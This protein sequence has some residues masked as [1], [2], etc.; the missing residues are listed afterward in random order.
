MERTSLDTVDMD[1]TIATTFAHHLRFTSD[2]L[3]PAN[4]VLAEALTVEGGPVRV[5]PFVDT[6]VAAAMPDLP[7]RLRTYFDAYES[8]ELAGRVQPVVGGELCKN[9]RDAV[10][11]VL[12]A[13]QEAGLDRQSFVLA[14]GGGAVLDCVGFAAAIAHRGM[15]LVRLPTTTL[16]QGDSGVGVKNGIN[17]FGQKN[18]LGSFAVPWAVINDEGFLATLSERDWRSGFSEAVKVALLKDADLFDQ[19]CEAAPAV[20]NRQPEVT[21]PLLQRSAELHLEHI[22]SGGDPFELGTGRPLDFGHWA[23]HKLETL[24]NF[25]LRHGEAVAI[26]LAIDVTYGEQV[27]CLPHDIAERVRQCLAAMG[28][29]LQHPAM[30]D[31]DVLL[32][33]LEEFRAHLGGAL[34]IPMI[35]DVGRPIEIN[36]IDHALLERAVAMLMMGADRDALADIPVGD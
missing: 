29:A 22:V 1:R 26:G 30:H 10:Y 15:R 21:V 18:Y 14:I 25:E 35:E 8:I 3:S 6:Q 27:G 11:R 24:T 16:A 19:L 23:A 34:S 36:A 32:A 7:E 28:F 33:G 12:E 5:L 9:D 2:V 17:G 31:L 13:I 4:A 20:R